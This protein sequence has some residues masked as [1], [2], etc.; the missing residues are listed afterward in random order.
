MTEGEYQ[1]VTG[2]SYTR[3]D[4]FRIIGIA[5]PGGGTWYTGYASH[6]GDWF[7][8]CGIGTPG[9]TGHD[10]HNHFVGADL[11][12]FGKTTTTIHQPAIRAITGDTS[13]VYLFYRN[14]NRGPFVF[15][16]TAKAKAV[17]DSTPVEVLWSFESTVSSI[18]FPEEIPDPGLFLEGAKKTITVNIYER[19][20]NARTACLRRWGLRCAVCSFDFKTKYGELGEGYIHV[21]HLRPLSEVGTAYELDPVRDLRPVCPNCHA[22]LHRRTPALD[23]A[24]LQEILHQEGLRGEQPVQGPA[25]RTT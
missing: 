12:W 9:R 6:R 11:V 2:R 7:I 13:R 4:V 17:K 8:F 22:M 10:Y 21:H 14:D 18:V 24:A 15:A 3:Q 20:A 19:D 5:D 23:I 16:G 1:F 25:H